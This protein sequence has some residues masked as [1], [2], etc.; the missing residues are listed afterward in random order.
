MATLDSPVCLSNHASVLSS[1]KGEGK[2]LRMRRVGEDQDG[3]GD[4]KCAVLPQTVRPP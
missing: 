2:A 3:M 4:W 1:R